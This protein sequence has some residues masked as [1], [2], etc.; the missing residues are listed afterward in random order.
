[1][2]LFTDGLG[3]WLS[4]II[5]TKAARWVTKTFI[6]LGVGLGSYALILQPLLDWA[7]AKWQAMPGNIAAWLHALGIDVAVSIILSA[8]GFKGTE[9]LFLR[10][11]DIP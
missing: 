6:G 3:V 7:V 10:R 5:I 1:M 8:Y 2:S 4:K 9:R 11:R